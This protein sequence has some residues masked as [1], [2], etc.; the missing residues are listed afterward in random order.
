MGYQ[1]LFF[2]ELVVV[3]EILMILPH[4][5][6]A[7]NHHIHVRSRNSLLFRDAVNVIYFS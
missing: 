1:T 3:H 5:E 4:H 6:T 7:V 2:K